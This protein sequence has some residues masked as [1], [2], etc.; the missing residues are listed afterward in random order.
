VSSDPRGEEARA[1]QWRDDVRA[2]IAY[3]RDVWRSLQAP[4]GPR[5]RVLDEW[6][7]VIAWMAERG[8]YIDPEE[9]P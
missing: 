2:R 6:A 4:P 5:Q 1:A 7:P 3:Q 9:D 8:V